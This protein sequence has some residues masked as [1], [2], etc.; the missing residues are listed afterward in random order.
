MALLNL[1]S[2]SGVV[3]AS[4]EILRIVDDGA[5][6]TLAEL[7][8]GGLITYREFAD[9]YR[10]WHGTD[11]DVRRV[12]DA[13]RQ[14]VERLPP[15]EVL[16]SVHEPQP[17]VAAR[18]SSQHDM[19]RVFSVRYY[20]GGPV[21]PPDAFSCYDGEVLLA[22]GN[23]PYIPRLDSSQVV[24]KPVVIAVPNDVAELADSAREVR[25]VLDALADPAVV[26]DRVA[27][28]ELGERLVS[29]RTA[30]DRAS[31]D[32]FSAAS[33][34]WLLLDN[35]R[36]TELQA[37]RGSAALSEA[38][39]AAY[40]CTP[41]VGNEMLNRTDLTAQGSKARRLL[42]EGMIER[43]DERDL[44][45]VGHGPEMAM[46]RAFLQRTQLHVK[47]SASASAGAFREPT[48]ESLLAAWKVMHEAF[49]RSKARRL[50]LRDVYAALLLPPVGMKAAVVPVFVTAGL[51]AVSDSIA[52]YEHGTFKP[53]L[54]PE[55]SERMVRNPGHFDIK[56]FA[57]TSGARSEVVRELAERLN[58]RPARGKRR[59]ANVL[60]IV[61]RLVSRIRQ[62]DNYTLR[63]SELPEA[64]RRAR[65]ALLDAVEPDELLFSALPE[66]LGFKSVTTGAKSYSAAEAYADAVGQVLDVL[67]NCYERL[68]DDLKKLLLDASA[69][70]NRLAV[71][72]Q[73]AALEDEVLDPDVRAFVYALAN[74][75]VDSD[76]DW[77]KGIATVVAK[78]APAEWTDDDR[79]RFQRE[80][81][82]QV[83]AFQRLRALHTQNRAHSPGAFDALRVTITR[84]NGREHIRLVSVDQA[85]RD[86]LSDALDR[87]VEELATV[88]GSAQRSNQALLALLSERL[89]PDPGGDQGFDAFSP[90]LF[91]NDE[92]VGQVASH[93]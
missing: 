42:L 46:Y 43:S 73:A 47:A 12:V 49:N 88:T 4:R 50:N 66:A 5:D 21:E 67:E 80:L 30:F 85:H 61:G 13:S 23:E 34:S 1:V 38:C 19:L 37:G 18:H 22:V 83:A 44:G 79:S 56:H 87:V 77:I 91:T 35:D 74:D 64:T 84:P 59:V 8:D 20:D 58:V 65:Q 17:M 15:V 39:D 55:M 72:R 52:I 11:V 68:L 14:Q 26:E 16:S 60:A 93:V 81:P 28:R 86:R 51:L 48:D 29:A 75:S 57:N 2:M 78:K 7:E 25:A 54:T 24:G 9:E 36:G 33:C 76:A 40:R 53:L 32:A 10:V 70:S 6:A 71:C 62:L 90:A 27:R 3:R 92:L 89:L 45:L 82:E 69:E 41:A 31:A 63:T